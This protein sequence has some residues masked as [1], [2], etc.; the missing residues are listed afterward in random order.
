VPLIFFALTFTNIDGFS[1]FFV[2]NFAG[3]FPATFVMLLPYRVK[4][5][6]TVV[7]SKLFK[8]ILLCKQVPSGFG[9]SYIVPLPQLKDCI[10]KVVM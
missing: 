5:S 1:Y 4:V 2:H 3:E 7:L 9:H 10:I 6:D 8:L